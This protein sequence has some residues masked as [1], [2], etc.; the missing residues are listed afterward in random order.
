MPYLIIIFCFISSGIFAQSNLGETSDPEAIAILKK[1]KADYD[2]YDAHKLEF[3]LQIELAGQGSETQ[4]GYLIQSGEKL[5]LNTGQQ[6]IMS[7]GETVWVYLKD[8]EEIQINDADFSEDEG[9]MSPSTVFEMYNSNEFIFAL[10]NTV[11]ENGKSF[12]E[13][14]AKPT[15]RYSEYAKFRITLDEKNKSITKMMIF[16]KDGSR[17]TL[18]ITAHRKG[19][20]VE[21]S[22]FV[23][24]TNKYPDAHV[25]DL[26][27]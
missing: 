1:I 18:N 27:F 4:S 19:I 22:T 5:V 8:I 11:S 6:Q 16:S 14:E 12:Q 23:M 9:F 26:R 2:K 10:G 17:Y 13:V 20:E 7:D 25:E 24:D 21:T 3:D 15:D